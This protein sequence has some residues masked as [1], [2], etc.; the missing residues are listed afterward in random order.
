MPIRG[1]AEEI[2]EHLK[3][4]GFTD[5]E[6]KVYIVLTTGGALNPTEIADLSNVP[7]PNVY[8]VI[9]RLENEGLVRKEA[10]KRGARYIAV[11]PREVIA[12]L[13]QKLKEQK[14]LLDA[15]KKLVKTLKPTE[16]SSAS[17]TIW[18]VNGEKEIQDLTMKLIKQAESQVVVLA[19][20]ELMFN[21]DLREQMFELLRDRVSKGVELIIGWKITEKDRDIATQLIET[22]TVYHWSLGET[23]IGVYTIDGKECLVTFIGKWAPKPIYDLAL[24]IKNPIYVKPFEY[25]TEKLL[26]LNVP[27]EERLEELR[28][29]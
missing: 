29:L 17:E 22:A 15:L 12:R 8:R 1:K 2:V 21:E 9:E 27:A 20:P 5:Y 28:K 4:L 18:L 11:P 6:S 25:L 13:D 3:Q 16:I 7:R 23:P 10:V 24:W 26:T 14:S 19:T